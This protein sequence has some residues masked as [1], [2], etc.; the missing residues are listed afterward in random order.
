ML[1][2]YRWLGGGASEGRS[3]KMSPIELSWVPQVMSGIWNTHGSM[4][5]IYFCS[6]YWPVLVDE[7]HFSVDVST[8]KRSGLRQTR[9]M[10]LQV[11]A[12][13][14]QFRGVLPSKMLILVYI[15]HCHC[16]FYSNAHT[17]IIYMHMWVY[18]CILYILYIHTICSMMSYLYT[19]IV[20]IQNV[21]E[22]QSR[23]WRDGHFDCTHSEWW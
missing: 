1:A 2:G 21:V 22:E 7:C 4:I 15:H 23:T 19:M 8:V 10:P 12:V 20:R 9:N 18:R 14:W 5:S 6:S 16:K 3:S 17:M 13:S 11:T